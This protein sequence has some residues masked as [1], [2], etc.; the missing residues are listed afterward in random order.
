[1]QRAFA[2]RYSPRSSGNRGSTS[3]KTPSK[4]IT[5]TVSQCCRVKSPTLL[6][7]SLTLELAAALPD[8]AGIID[9]LHTKPAV[10]MGDGE[11]A[12]HLERYL[13]GESA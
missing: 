13:L 5:T 1:M 6:Q 3:T 11:I 10:P 4:S 2:E 12:D 7:S 9:R 8:V